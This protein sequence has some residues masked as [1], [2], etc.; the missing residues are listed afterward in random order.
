MNSPSRRY[1]KTETCTL[2]FSSAS[3]SPIRLRSAPPISKD[4]KI[5]SSFFGSV[6]NAAFHFFFDTRMVGEQAMQR[7]RELAAQHGTAVHPAFGLPVHGVGAVCDIKPPR[8]ILVG[9]KIRFGKD[10]CALHGLSLA[11]WL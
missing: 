10:S 7:A 2:L 6:L 4:G 3:N 11:V 1:R 9:V 8:G 5:K